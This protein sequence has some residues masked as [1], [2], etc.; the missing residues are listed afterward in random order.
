MTRKKHE[1]YE[2][3][4]ITT[5]YIF[6]FKLHFAGKHNLKKSCLYHQVLFTVFM[7]CRIFETQ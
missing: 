3:S 2:E 7:R 4:Q 5:T 1:E 6:G